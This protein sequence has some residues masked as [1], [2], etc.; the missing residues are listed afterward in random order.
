MRILILP[1]LAVLSASISHANNAEYQT[2]SHVM[3]GAAGGSNLHL[4][5]PADSKSLN[6]S[7]PQEPRKP[8]LHPNRRTTSELGKKA[9]M[10]GC[11]VGGIGVGIYFGLQSGI[12]VGLF[13][14]LGGVSLGFFAATLLVFLYRVAT[15]K[16]S[17]PVSRPDPA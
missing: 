2:V 9:Q 5:V 15:S 8:N 11:V 7:L 13:G 10:V 4:T 12:L 16:A 14:A 6:V 1:L 17:L 3:D